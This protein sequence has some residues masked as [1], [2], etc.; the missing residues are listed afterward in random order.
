M[1]SMTLICMG[2]LKEKFYIQASEEYKKRLGAFCDFTLLELPEVRLPENPNETQILQGLAKE[3]EIIRAK[4]PKGSWLCIFAPEGKMLSSEELAGKLSELKKSGKSSVCFLI[5]SSFGVDA[6][7]KKQADL[8]LSMSRMT[9]PHHLARVMALEQLYRAE[10]IQAG[11]KYHIYALADTEQSVFA[12][13]L[14]R[15]S[16][17]CILSKYPLSVK[18]NPSTVKNCSAH[19]G[20]T[21]F[22][23]KGC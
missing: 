17:Q 9:F 8:L 7:L 6:G 1:F 10:A 13:F 14:F 11:T 18:I 22:S 21:E 12:R 4:V 19:A 16:I 20:L 15:L 23:G 2:K 3:A 5:G